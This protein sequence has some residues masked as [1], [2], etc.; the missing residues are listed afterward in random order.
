MGRK[1]LG[2]SGLIAQLVL[3]IS[4]Y[5]KEYQKKAPKTKLDE[6]V[7]KTPKSTIELLIKP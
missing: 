3:L 6:N 2:L 4:L 7:V 5:S 1:L